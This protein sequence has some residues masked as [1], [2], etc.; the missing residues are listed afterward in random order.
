[1]LLVLARRWSRVVLG[2]IHLAG[3]RRRWALQ[4]AF[5]QRVKARGRVEG[6]GRDGAAQRSA[7]SGATTAAGH[8]ARDGETAGP[9][10]GAAC[11]VSRPVATSGRFVGPAVVNAAEP[12]HVGGHP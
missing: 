3:L 10:P 7:T 5:L 2:A 1:M 11:A 9:E 4:G 6:D 12:A 8:G